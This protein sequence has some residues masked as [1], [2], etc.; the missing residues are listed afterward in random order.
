MKLFRYN[1]DDIYKSASYYKTNQ[2]GV[3]RLFGY[4]YGRDWQK[5]FEHGRT[6]ML[7][8]T[9]WCN[10]MGN[11]DEFINSDLSVMDRAIIIKIASFREFANYDLYGDNTIRV[12][13]IK[14]IPMERVEE[15]SLIKIENDKIKL[16]FED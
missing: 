11:V 3:V 6:K 15:I 12:E 7:D 5:F 4:L 16:T 10:Y 8:T 14:D 1:F 9:R 13:R 2:H